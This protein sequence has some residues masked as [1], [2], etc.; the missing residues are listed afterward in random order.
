VVQSIILPKNEKS[1]TTI[2][3]IWNARDHIKSLQNLMAG[4]I[5]KLES[6]KNLFNWTVPSKTFPLYALLVATWLATILIPG[7]YLIL[8]GL[9]PLPSL[10]PHFAFPVGISEFFFIFM[11]QPEE[12][13]LSIK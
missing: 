2:S 13:P 5:D 11:P 10:S 3:A 4:V 9:L 12:L 7:R 1:E 8:L 6:L